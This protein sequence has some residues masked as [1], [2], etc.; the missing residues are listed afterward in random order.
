MQE[1]CEI[2]GSFGGFSWTDESDYIVS[3]TLPQCVTDMIW[4]D[5]LG[6][7][8]DKTDDERKSVP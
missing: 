1:W 3:V 2:L 7:K 5:D 8:L 4:H 6:T